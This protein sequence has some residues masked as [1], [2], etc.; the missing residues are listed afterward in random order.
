MVVRKGRPAVAT[1]MT[2]TLSGDHRA[3]DGALGAELLGAFKN[4]I[5]NPLEMLA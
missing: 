2:V 1:V 5:E 4:Y 3:I